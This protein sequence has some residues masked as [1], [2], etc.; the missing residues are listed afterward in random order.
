MMGSSGILR[1]LA[2]LRRARHGES[3]HASGF[4]YYQYERRLSPVCAPC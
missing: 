3:Q 1:G 2:T 4:P